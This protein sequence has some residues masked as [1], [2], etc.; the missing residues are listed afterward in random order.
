MPNPMETWVRANKELPATKKSAINFPFMTSSYLEKR[1]NGAS[2]FEPSS[3][4]NPRTSA[5]PN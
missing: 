2:G 1:I 3:G 5:I 4:I